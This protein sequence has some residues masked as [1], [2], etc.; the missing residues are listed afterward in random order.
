MNFFKRAAVS[1]IRRKGKTI[2][3]LALIFVLGNVI[4]GAVSIEQAVKNT[5]K[6]VMR[7][8]NPIATIQL[9]KD[10][11][12]GEVEWGA[13]DATEKF[14]ALWSKYQLTPEQIEQFGELSSVDYLEYSNICRLFSRDIQRYVPPQSVINGTED[15]SNGAYFEFTGGQ[16]PEI[17]DCKMGVIEMT[18]GSTLTEAEISEGENKVVVSKAFAETNGLYVG[19]VFTLNHEIYE[20]IEPEP[21]DIN[22]DLKAGAEPELLKTLE[23]EFTVTGIY[24]LVENSDDS[25]NENQSQHDAWT[26]MYRLTNQN[27]MIYTSNNA[28]RAINGLIL[29]QE[30]QYKPD[31][32][33]EIQLFSDNPLEPF[34]M[35]KN[36]D[37]LEEFK[38]EIASVLD[39]EYYNIIDSRGDY[40]NIIAPLKNM[41]E[42]SN[43]I[44][45]VGIAASLVILSL[46][47]TL[48]L[49]DRRN[50]IGIYLAL[51]E[52]KIRI[53][54]Q[55]VCEVLLVSVLGIMLS[56]F[57]GN[58]IAGGLSDSMMENQ[59]ISQREQENENRGSLTGEEN[60]L[61]SMG[62]GSE[63]TFDELSEQYRVS[64]DFNIVIFFFGAGVITVFLSTLI[65]ILYTLKL[66]PRK[67]LM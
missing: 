37:A 25:Q 59:V 26:Q 14:R 23:F 50:E 63:I 48:F 3:L 12:S 49:R 11:I 54:G 40:T 10:K 42:L 64:L 13:D 22:T 39:S 38:T 44:L 6:A 53:A 30:K 15:S 27:N 58:I 16:S 8:I 34:Y 5:E 2:I 32:W 20:Y 65:P 19:A 18:D 21:V 61:I 55:I 17:L 1:I 41:S 45:F 4:A 29:A 56:L 46:L 60:Y 66:N 35:F 47:I 36:V 52:R 67:I 43:T 57:S 62:Y 33:T 24:D 51:G 28:I 31:E 7:G 9:S